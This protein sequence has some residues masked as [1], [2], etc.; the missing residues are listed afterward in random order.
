MPR[1]ALLLLVSLV[2]APAFAATLVGVVLDPNRTPVAGAEVTV[3]RDGVL[4]ATATTGPDGRFQLESVAAGAYSVDAASPG[5]S[6]GAA[7]AVEL[8]DGAGRKQIELILDPAA[9]RTSIVV[10]EAPER[11]AASKLDI[12]LAELPVTVNTTHAE[13]MRQQGNY[14][15]VNALRYTANLQARV[16]FGVY[17]HFTV[18][19]L[20]DVIQMVDGIR[21]EDRRFNTQIVNVEQV[22]VLKGPAAALY[23]NNAVGGSIN[24]IR[25][26]PRNER[27]LELG[28][29]GGA[30]GNKRG[31]LGAAG[32]LVRDRLMY[33]F[34]YG[35]A[36]FEGYRRAPLRQHLASGA[37]LWRP[38]AQDQLHVNYQ[39]NRDRFATDAGFPTFANSIPRI[40]TDRRFNPPGDRA[41]TGDHFLQAYYHRNWS[42]NFEFR[43][44]LSFRKFRDDYLSAETM[45]ITPPSTVNRT[46]F[47]FD[48][49]RETL[50]NQVEVIGRFATGDVRHYLLGGYEFQGFRQEDDNATATNLRI[51]PIDLFAP[52]ET[53]GPVAIVKNRTRF[54]RQSVNAFYAQDHV[55][56]S[57]R[58]SAT[59]N[60]RYDPWRRNFRTDPLDPATGFPTTTGPITFLRQNAWTGRA[61]AVYRLWRSVS[62]Y[63]SWG[64]AFTP[65][66]SVPV[67][68]ALLE[69]ERSRQSE[70]GIRADLFGRR[71]VVTA[72]VFHLEKTNQTIALGG[73]RFAQAGRV[74]S[75]GTDISI[76]S[77][78]TSR[79]T[80]RLQYGLSDAAF[81]RFASGTTNLD[82]RT[83]AFAPRHTGNAWVTYQI[84]GPL[85]IAGGLR[86][87][88][89]S[90]T[91]F[92]NTL[93]M[94]GHALL[95]A[96]VMY[97][98]KWLDA[99][100]TAQNV[101]NRKW[102]FVGSVYNTQVYPGTP[103]ALIANLRLKWAQRD[104]S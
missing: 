104:G 89:R 97:Y 39:Y 13:L 29:T 54:I 103:F 11:T 52:V 25:K 81:L 38:S 62:V 37:V 67:D 34:D 100:V 16:N 41:L 66:L 61:G 42:E 92:F 17:E 79:L 7:I 71:A 80:A 58:L 101:A 30:W 59:F 95:D 98:S 24:V 21:Q 33:R 94:P 68:N 64:N 28:L 36:D 31:N 22:E 51:A 9:L 18:R 35:F 77:Y 14:D 70:A 19:G 15:L 26:K 75:Q 10:Y 40:P 74:R 87:M 73:G 46:L 4:V 45:S 32:P 6:S 86:A 76:D 53:Q 84:A 85:A 57:D 102:Y 63:G 96:A 90:Y 83:P 5:F 3:R 48:R 47:Y 43:N 56:F 93:A 20:G 12:P 78:L 44:V 88:D 69:P 23:G 2:P 91:S 50:L 82:G 55:R 27:E 8:R 65:V 60:I 99:S 72:A 49:R 1:S